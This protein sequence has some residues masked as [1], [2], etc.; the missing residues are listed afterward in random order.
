MTIKICE[1]E[2][3]KRG[4]LKLHCIPSLTSVRRFIYKQTL[5]L[6]ELKVVMLE[7]NSNPGFAACCMSACGLVPFPVGF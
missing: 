4:T 5:V 1:Q 3:E 7:K 2:R 6:W